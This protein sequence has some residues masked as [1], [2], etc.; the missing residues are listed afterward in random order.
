MHSSAILTESSNPTIAKKASAVAEVIASR[1]PESA[2][3][4]WVSLL[5]SP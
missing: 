3:L 1:T 4:I 2:V 5:G